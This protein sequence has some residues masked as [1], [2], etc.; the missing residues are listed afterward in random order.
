[1]PAVGFGPYSRISGGAPLHFV[2]NRVACRISK[3][4]EY[5]G[6]RTH[7]ALNSASELEYHLLVARDTGALQQA[8]FASLTAATVSV[9]KMLY[10]FVE[11]LESADTSQKNQIPREILARSPKPAKPKAAGR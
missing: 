5:G 3:N 4:S 10:R 9:R 2:T 11:L 7:W 1:M 6:R 8:E